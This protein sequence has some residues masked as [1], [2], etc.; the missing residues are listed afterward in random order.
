MH[1]GWIRVV[2]ATG[3]AYPAGVLIFSFRPAG[4]VI[5]EAAVAATAP[6][7]AFRLYVEKDN[8]IRT[9]F[10]IANPGTAVAQVT[11]ELTDLNGAPVGNALTIDPSAVVSVRR[12]ALAR[13][14]SVARTAS[15]TRSQSNLYTPDCRMSF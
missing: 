12:P 6:S 13:E 10:A 9:G 11:Y 4:V 8:I 1:I 14:G 3:A 2:P 7:S 15:A 5:T